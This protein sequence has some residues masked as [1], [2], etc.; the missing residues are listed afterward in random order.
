MK[1]TLILIL[2]LSSAV[3]LFAQSTY[4]PLGFETYEYMDRFDIK[5]GKILPV[6][7]TANKPYDMKFIAHHNEVLRA[8]NLTLG[9]TDKFNSDYLLNDNSEWYD[10]LKS[11]SKK[12][13]L[14]YFYREPANLYSIRTK[15]DEFVLRINPILDLGTGT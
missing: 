1:K 8:S 12:P 7:H 11:I 6:F 4:A 5:Y 10:S 14:R 15:K 2:V 3:F 9:K 13:F